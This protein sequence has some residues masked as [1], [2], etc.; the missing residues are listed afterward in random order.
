MIK[1][2]AERRG[3]YVAWSL[4]SFSFGLY[5]FRMGARLWEVQLGFGPLTV[6]YDYTR[7]SE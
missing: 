6:G 4:Y 2:L 7:A 3:F 5:V 1:T